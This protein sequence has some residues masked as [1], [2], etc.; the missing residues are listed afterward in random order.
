MV[1]LFGLDPYTFDVM[2]CMAQFNQRN[3][4]ETK[5]KLHEVMNQ[6]LVE[7][8]FTD[9]SMQ[10]AAFQQY[11]K[12]REHRRAQLHRR[13]RRLERLQKQIR[14]GGPMAQM[15]HPKI[16]ELQKE[17]K[18]LRKYIGPRS[19]T[20]PE[21]EKAFYLYQEGW[22]IKTVAKCMKKKLTYLQQWMF[23]IHREELDD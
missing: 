9:R 2:N 1:D 13:M 6:Y 11:T 8:G 10:E 4:R 16:V 23:R 21:R 18:Q 20:M 15:I 12:K 3:Y 17:I 7:K 5:M 22:G 19:L 14:Y